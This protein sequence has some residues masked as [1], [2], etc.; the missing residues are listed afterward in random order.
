[1]DL[2]DQLQSLFPDHEFSQGKKE[3]EASQRGLWVQDAPLRCKYE[4]RHGKATVIIQGYTGD[5]EDF[6]RLAKEIKTELG[7]GGSIK[8]ETIILQGDFRPQIMQILKEYG[9][10]VKPVGG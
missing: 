4:K 8:D 6:K 1:M 2:Q 5:K 7:I 10:K 9:F 3:A